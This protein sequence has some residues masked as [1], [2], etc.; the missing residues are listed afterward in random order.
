MDWIATSGS[1]SA[2]PQAGR[3][4]ASPGFPVMIVDSQ[5]CACVFLFVFARLPPTPHPPLSVY[6]SLCLCLCSHFL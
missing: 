5:V 2:G 1:Y 4:P 3:T 6:L